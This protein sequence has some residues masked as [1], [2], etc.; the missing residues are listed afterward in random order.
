VK[1]I[2]LT[3]QKRNI[4]FTVEDSQ[5][6]HQEKGYNFWK[7]KYSSW[8]NETFNFLDKFLS[9]EKDYLDIGSWVG[10]T[11]IYASH[12]CR[13]AIAIEPD[14]VAYRILN[15]NISLNDI[16][17]I[18][19]INKAVSIFENSFMSESKFFGDSMTRVSS[20][21]NNGTPI[22]TIGLDDLISMGDF[23]L[24]KMDIEGSEFDVIPYYS[25][26]LEEKKIPLYLS[27]HGPFFQDGQE[28]TSA[29]IKS[30]SSAKEVY[31]EN[32]DRIDIREISNNFGSYFFR[33]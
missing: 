20:N 9:K 4:S 26:L 11:V 23:S 15:T 27:V 2:N 14:P 32:G 6:L 3:V 30:L 1:S 13:N 10:P 22:E 28:K 12:L 24:I 17:N 19:T 7:E 21:S 33:W 29:L 25:S 16:S 31:S 18:R 5:E 8:E